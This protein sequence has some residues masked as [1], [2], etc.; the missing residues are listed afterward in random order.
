MFRLQKS[1]I[2]AIA[3]GAIAIAALVADQLTKRFVIAHVYFDGQCLPWCGHKEI[4]PGWLR[5]APEPNY[6][7]AFGMLGSNA[8][9]LIAMALLVLV[10]FWIYFREATERSTLV[11]IAFGLILGGAVSNII[12]RVHYGYVIDFIDFYRFPNI[13]R[14][15]FNVADS[16]I[17]IGVVLLLI[18]SVAS[19]RHA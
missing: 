5:I 12:D 13:W 1:S 18:S 19:R 10:I 7:G 4:V 14:F 6:H 17:T 16:C 15:T 2:G 11:R 3:I 8:F 9:L